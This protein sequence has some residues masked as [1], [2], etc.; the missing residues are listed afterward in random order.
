MEL[1]KAPQNVKDLIRKFSSDK[2]ERVQ[3]TEEA[4]KLADI[5]ILEKV[6]GRTSL[7]DWRHI[8]VA[9]INRVDVFASWNFKH[10]VN[11]DKI[12]GYNSIN[13]RL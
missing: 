13:Y 11:L 7:E 5:Y 3:L 2:F 12:K 6:V 8:A 10:I 9:T 4:I 1:I